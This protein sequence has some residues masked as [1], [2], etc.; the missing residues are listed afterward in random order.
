[1]PK[2]GLEPPPV[3]Y[4][5]LDVYKRQRPTLPSH[6]PRLRADLPL[7]RSLSPPRQAFPASV[8]RRSKRRLRAP[9]PA[10]P[11]PSSSPTTPRSR[12]TPSS[13]KSC[14][15]PGA[16]ISRSAVV[17]SSGPAH[18]AEPPGPS[19]PLLCNS[20]Q[21]QEWVFGLRRSIEMLRP[22]VKAPG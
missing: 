22:G 10:A 21:R 20:E 12:S 15:R 9:K 13:S 16:P 3:S 2:K 18:S 17:W 8:K 14:R 1:M 6:S 19:L 5:H 4:T 11:S 7:P